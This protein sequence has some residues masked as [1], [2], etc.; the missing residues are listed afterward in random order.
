MDC[1]Y[2]IRK[3]EVQDESGQTHTVYGVEAWLG[4]KKIRCIPDV[5]FV[6][7]RAEDFVYRCNTYELS[8]V[9]LMDVIEDVLAEAEPPA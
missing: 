7:R 8:L 9:H 3:D 4:A 6:R 2:T 1:R 5:F